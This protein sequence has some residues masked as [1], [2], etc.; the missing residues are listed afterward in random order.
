MNRFAESTRNFVF[1]WTLN[2]LILLFG[3]FK[4]SLGSGASE[5]RSVPTQSRG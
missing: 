1:E 3:I 5:L 2:I 4:L